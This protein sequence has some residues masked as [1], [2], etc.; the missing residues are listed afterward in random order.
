MESSPAKNAVRLSQATPLGLVLVLLLAACSGT[1]SA[2]TTATPTAT[3]DSTVKPSAEPEATPVEPL[4][5]TVGWQPD[6]NAALYLAREQRLFEKH[7]LTPEFV[8]FQAAPAMFAALSSASIDVADMGAVPYS[9]ALS[10]GIDLSYLMVAVDVSDTNALVTREGVDDFAGLRGMRV[11]T[12]KGSSPYLLL[13]NLL[14]ANE[15]T[16]DDIQFIDMQVSNMVPAWENGDVDAI[17]AW[18]PWIYR[19]AGGNI[20]TTMAD[21]DLY[22][23][24]VWA[25]RG[26]WAN[27]N[28]EAARRFVAVISEALEIVNSDPQAAQQ[29]MMTHLEIDATLAE[30]L[31]EANRYP[32]AEEQLDPASPTALVSEGGLGDALQRIADLLYENGFIEDLPD[33]SS[34][35]ES[36]FLEDVAG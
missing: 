32:T 12:T 3:S 2:S 23:P 5:I 34:T 25:A 16:L 20:L 31:Y 8:T 4:P 33:I 9:V 22:A 28:A 1:P 29:A 30:T 35:Q 10:Q 18:S 13:L 27:D 14:E 17:L 21:N 19:M 26:A 15:M 36:S 11:A 6:P 24:Q 7:G